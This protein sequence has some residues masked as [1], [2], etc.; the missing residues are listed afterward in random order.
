MYGNILHPP[1]PSRFR[2]TQATKS[3]G[4]D[5]EAWSVI[6]HSSLTLKEFWD[7]PLAW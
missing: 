1:E 2:E 5:L 7:T 3:C 4:I 6:V